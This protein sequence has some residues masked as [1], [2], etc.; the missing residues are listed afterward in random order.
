MNVVRRV[1]IA[2]RGADPPWLALRIGSFAHTMMPHVCVANNLT[3]PMLPRPTDADA[4]NC[5]DADADATHKAVPERL[6][7]ALLKRRNVRALVITLA[8]SIIWT[9]AQIAGALL[10]HSSSLMSDALAMCVDAAAYAFNLASESRPENERAIKLA[11][12]SISA[13]ILLVVTAV[14]LNDAINTLMGVD[15]TDEVDGALVLGFGAAMLF[16][17]ITM[18]CAIFFRGMAGGLEN[19]SE[20]QWHGGLCHV[21]PREELNLF[22]GLS[23]VVADTLRSFTQVVVGAVILAGGPSEM[24]DACGT[25]AISCTILLGAIFLLY[26]VALQWQAPRQACSSVVGSEGMRMGVCTV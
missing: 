24:V 4:C 13:A 26:E 18:L 8:V 5:C 21:S 15:D 23:H 20:R 17:D 22:S 6:R 11:A 16:A 14:S 7:K 3:E 10:S 19:G 25:L 12:P 9:A 2:L 1:F